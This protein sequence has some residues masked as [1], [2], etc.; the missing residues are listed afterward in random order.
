MTSPPCLRYDLGSAVQ[1]KIKR[2]HDLIETQIHAKDMFFL[3]FHVSILD[4]A[5]V[6]RGRHNGGG[7]IGEMKS[8]CNLVIG[9]SFVI[10]GPKFARNLVIRKSF[11]I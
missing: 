1:E 5:A 2:F 10:W 4:Q 3:C 7:A 9:K 11:V 6:K 8:G